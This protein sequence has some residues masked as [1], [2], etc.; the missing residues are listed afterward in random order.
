M[1]RRPEL[2]RLLRSRGGRLRL[3]WRLGLWLA[4]A[5][6]VAAVS[7]ILLPPGV[8][9]GSLAL[10]VGA[11]VAGT[12]VL[13]L[14]DR[15][16]AALG[17]PL[18]REAV[19]A[20]AR[21]LALGTLVALAVVALMAALGGLR[22]TSEE[23]TAGAWL[24]GSGG[25]VLFLALPAAAEEALLRGYPLQA[26]AE[27]WGPAAALAVTSVVFGLLHRGNPG[28]TTVATLNVVAAGLFLGVV[29]LR[30]A[31]LWWATGAHLGWNWAHGYLA[32]VPVSGLELLDAP[33][34]EGVAQGPA[35]LGGGSFG[36]EGSLV[37]TVVVLA[38]SLLCWRAR[39]LAPSAAARAARPL[40][41]AWATPPGP[42]APGGGGAS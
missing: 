29:Y 39:W 23:G 42:R 28:V 17:F 37:A 18:G 22:W 36:P 41:L 14:D 19:G 12:V 2:E 13:A 3:G 25:A 35:W 5:L 38:A 10:L 8:Q 33:F 27:A 9:T 24:L 16:P 20:S 30:T 40:A 26:L 32:D 31:S 4:L 7:A 34:Y 11:V 21:G 1:A 15:P 6:F